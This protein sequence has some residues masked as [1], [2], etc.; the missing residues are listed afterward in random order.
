MFGEN[1]LLNACLAE[2]MQLS[3][4]IGTPISEGEIEPLWLHEFVRLAARVPT[5]A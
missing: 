3:V 2:C 4:L 1:A 5:Q